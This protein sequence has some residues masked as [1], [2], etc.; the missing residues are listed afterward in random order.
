MSDSKIS[1]AVI[2]LVKS[3]AADDLAAAVL[4]NALND[5]LKELKRLSEKTDMLDY[6]KRDF[7]NHVDD[8]LAI[9][10]A[11][12]YFTCTSQHDP[13]DEADELL[14]GYAMRDTLEKFMD[15]IKKGIVL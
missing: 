15:Q 3:T 4:M 6:E 8:G 1:N 14:A 9:S 13:L 7:S 2:E 12:R 10:L 5:I 11:A